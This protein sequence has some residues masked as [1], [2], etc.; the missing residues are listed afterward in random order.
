MAGHDA[1][2]MR[3]PAIPPVVRPVVAIPPVPVHAAPLSRVTTSVAR[4]AAPVTAT[5]VPAVSDAMAD[6]EKLATD[7]TVGGAVDTAV[8]STHTGKNLAA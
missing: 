2:R 3:A 7:G 5:L 1:V 8:L 4:R 6:G